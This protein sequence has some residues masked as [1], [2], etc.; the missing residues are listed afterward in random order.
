MAEGVQ[1]VGVNAV[2]MVNK[3]EIKGLCFHFWI[4]NSKWI[5][6]LESCFI[7]PAVNNKRKK[8]F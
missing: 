2:L 7:K 1:S 5:T 6:V 3:T 8:L 4:G